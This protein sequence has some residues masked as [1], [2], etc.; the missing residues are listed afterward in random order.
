M[1]QLDQRIMYS[2]WYFAAFSLLQSIVMNCSAGRIS[3]S[4]SSYFY[5]TF[6]G[7]FPSRS[8]PTVEQDHGGGGY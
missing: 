8:M 5:T 1:M 6:E 7:F 4:L 2:T 3:F